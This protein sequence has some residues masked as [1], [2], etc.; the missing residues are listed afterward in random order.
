MLNIIIPAFIIAIIIGLTHALLGR[1]ILTKNIIFIDLAIAQIAG[2]AII[3]ANI[4]F[5]DANIFIIEIFA[6]AF[7]IIA[8]IIFYIIEKKQPKLQEAIIGSSFILFST[9]TM[10]ILSNHPHGG[11]EIKYLLSGQIL[12]TDFNNLLIHVPIYLTII[13]LWFRFPKVREGVIF[14][15]IFAIAITSSVQIAGV[16]L[17]FTSLVLPAI[18]TNDDNNYITHSCI[19]SL[20]STISGIILTIIFDYEAGIMIVLSYFVIASLYYL[21][22]KLK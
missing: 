17:V 10:L 9:L 6:L 1:N 20:I 7:A 16:Y 15:I 12:F 19:Y 8:A 3:L 11:E 21:N 18:I 22:S 13:L 5:H 4:I 14:Y 2:F